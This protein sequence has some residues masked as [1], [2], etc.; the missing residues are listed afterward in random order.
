[1]IVGAALLLLAGGGAAWAVTSGTFVPDEPVPN[2]IGMPWG[3]A[4]AAVA[5]EHLHLTVTGQEYSDKAA[6]DVVTQS[7]AQGKLK[8]GGDVRV[9]V[10]KGPAPV[11]VPAIVGSSLQD[12][13]RVL[14]GLGL[15][16]TTTN[17]SSM[18][19]ARDLVISTDPSSGTIIP[20]QSMALVVSSGKPKVAVPAITLGSEP[21]AQAEAALKQV[22]LAYTATVTYSNTV[23][24][25]DVIAVSPA[26]GAQAEIG[27][28]V[29]L[30]ISQGPHYAIVPPTK[31]DSVGAA[32]E[33]LDAAGF[34]VTGVNGNPTNTVKGTD[35][36]A[37]QQVL[38]GSS[39]VIVT[40]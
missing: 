4:T 38:Y 10:S 18:T 12:A 21:V 6:G 17:A 16:W 11:R 24:R 9:V 36:P 5:N 13:I 8:R 26:S 29:A 22:G 1:V 40:H 2:V 34:N 30:T 39:I 20:G 15:K 28:T 32:T 23:P 19:V 37:G 25:N 33:A 35:P 14:Q 27:S 3:Q 7:P 31:D